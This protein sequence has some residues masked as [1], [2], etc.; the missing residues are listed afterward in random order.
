LRKGSDD[1]GWLSVLGL[2]ASPDGKRLIL[3]LGIED[4]C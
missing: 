2:S 4:G 1:E 3:F